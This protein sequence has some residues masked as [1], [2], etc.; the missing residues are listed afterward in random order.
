VPLSVAVNMIYFTV[1]H[2][3]SEMEAP[4]GDDLMG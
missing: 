1:D 3:A 4:F 2:C